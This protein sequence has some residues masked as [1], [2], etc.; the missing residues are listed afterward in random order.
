M[1]DTQTHRHTG[2]RALGTHR[3][4]KRAQHTSASYVLL[5]TSP[6]SFSSLTV[7]SAV[8]EML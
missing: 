1:T 3:V 2:T 7:L 5:L 4:L 8:A 6:F